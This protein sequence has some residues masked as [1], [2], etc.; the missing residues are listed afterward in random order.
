MRNLLKMCCLWMFCHLKRKFC[1]K[2]KLQR[3]HWVVAKT[4]RFSIAWML[5]LFTRRETDPF[6]HTLRSP[7]MLYLSKCS[8]YCKRLKIQRKRADALMM[9]T[10]FEVPT[11]EASMACPHSFFIH[12]AANKCGYCGT[13]YKLIAN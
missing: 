11:V 6:C 5:S 9:Q 2:R 3:K 1:L 7:S 8:E 13:R 12:F 4:A 10:E